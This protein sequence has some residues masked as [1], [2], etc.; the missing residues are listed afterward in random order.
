MREIDQAHGFIAKQR[1]AFGG[2]AAQNGAR[3]F[4]VLRRSAGE[5]ARLCRKG[6]ALGQRHG[7][8]S[9]TKTK[10]FYFLCRDAAGV[11]AGQPRAAPGV[12]AVLGRE[13]GDGLADGFGVRAANEPQAASQALVKNVAERVGNRCAGNATARFAMAVEVAFMKAIA[14][15]GQPAKQRMKISDGGFDAVSQPGQARAG[16]SRADM[17]HV[18]VGGAGPGGEAH[19]S[20][21]PGQNSIEQREG[22][23]GAFE[24]KAAVERFDPVEPRGQRLLVGLRQGRVVALKKISAG[25]FEVRAHLG[26]GAGEPAPREFNFPPVDFQQCGEN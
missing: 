23:G 20:A 1:G 3:D 26:R 12:F 13:F 18:D 17:Q 24:G 9:R 25:P 11:G 19:E 14:I 10:V 16:P 21:S 15:D 4:G 2:H 6:R 22:H 5:P 7:V 8:P